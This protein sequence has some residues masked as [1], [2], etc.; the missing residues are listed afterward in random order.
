[1]TE[2]GRGLGGE[3]KGVEG[4]SMRQRKGNS[5]R[6]VET[7][8][9]RASTLLKR[10]RFRQAIHILLRARTKNPKS[11]LVYY[12]LG[13]A[14]EAIKQYRLAMDHYQRALFLDPSLADAAVSQGY[15][16]GLKGDIKR[17]IARY[18]E[19]LLRDPRHLVALYNKAVVLDDKL[20]NQQGAIPLYLRVLRRQLTAK[21]Q[22]DVYLR[23]TY[24]YLGT[25]QYGRA[26]RT[27]RCLMR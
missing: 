13:F 9:V 12:N 5:R 22:S 14:Y 18:D 21:Q 17:E 6:F 27:I 19:V 4:Y 20:D 24:A 7:A 1:M 16:F 23:L 25:R 2:A 3:N 26:I 15:I 11:A 10:N 8:L